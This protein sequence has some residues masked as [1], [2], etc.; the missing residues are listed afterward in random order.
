MT[1]ASDNVYPRLLISEG[2]STATPSANRVTVY[3]KSDG[4]L[5]S[6]DDAGAETALGGVADITDIPTAEMDDTLV[7][8]PDG[9]GGVEFRAEVGGSGGR[10]Y[11]DDHPALSGTYGDD[12]TGASLDGKWTRG[13]DIVAGDITYQQGDGSHIYVNIPATGG[14]V[15]D[16]IYQS[17]APGS[18]FSVSTSMTWW[19]ANAGGGSNNLMLGVGIIDSSGSGIAAIMYQGSLYTISLTSY[20]Y[21][22]FRNSIAVISNGFEHYRRTWL[23]C[24][25][26]GTNYYA[27]MSWDGINWSAETAAYSN[28]FTVERLIVGCFWNNGGQHTL[29]IGHF[30]AA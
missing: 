6:K 7:L 29:A 18:D 13:A 15:A 14:A 25:K 27:S 9:T 10:P 23:R 20:K 11:L 26:S 2:G 22:N 1:K 21:S 17:A 3:A 19:F 4:L 30:N 24:R 12:F 16:I 8:A 5:Y 28:A